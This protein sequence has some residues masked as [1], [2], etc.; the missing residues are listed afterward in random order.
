MSC[1]SARVGA[2]IATALLAAGASSETPKTSGLASDLAEAVL[3]ELLEH[4]VVPGPALAAPSSGGPVTGSS[5]IEGLDAERL[6]APIRAA[7]VA[8]GADPELLRPDAPDRADEL[9]AKLDAFALD[10]A[11]AFVDEIGGNAI[12][13]GTGLAASNTP[14]SPGTVTGSAKITG[15]NPVRLAVPIRTALV[16]KMGAADGTG[17]A[18][19][20]LALASAVLGELL[21]F[22]E[23]VPVDPLGAIAGGGPLVGVLEVT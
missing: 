1:D 5:T 22:A 23:V 17:T 18:T 2:L 6:A 4:A 11:T 12:V 16:E 9:E 15:L 10:L 3:G 14:V 8:A 7:F 21:V 13:P 20:A 19:L